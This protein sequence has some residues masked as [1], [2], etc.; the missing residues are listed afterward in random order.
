MEHLNVAE[1]VDDMGKKQPEALAIA[2]LKGAKVHK[3][4]CKDLMDRSN[5]LAWA[6]NEYGIGYGMHTAMMVTPGEELFALTFALFKVGAVPVFIDPGMGLDNVTKCLAEAK[7]EAFIGLTKA[8]I[9]R[10]LKGWGK[11][12][13]KKFVTV[14]PRLFF[15]GL[16]YNELLKRGSGKKLQIVEVTADTPA[17]INFTSGSTGRAKGA[18]Y[19]HGMFSTQVR[20]IRDVY[21]IKAGEVDCST[22]PLFALFD[23]AMGMTSVIPDMDTSKPGSSNPANIVRAVHLF[24]CTNMFA[25]PVVVAKVGAYCAK[26]G[27]K[28]P[29]LK[30]VISCGA[31]VAVPQLSTFVKALNNETQVH[32]PYG[33][34]EALPISDIGSKEIFAETAEITNNGG[35]VC[36][37]RANPEA[38]IKVITITDEAL[39][40]FDPTLELGPN[41]MGEIIVRG[42]MVSKSYFGRDDYTKLAKINDKDGTFWHRMGDVGYFDEKGRLFMCGRKSHRVV[43]KERT[44]Y[45][46]PSE[47]VFNKCAKIK[48]SALVGIKQNGETKA[49]ICIELPKNSQV[50]KKALKEELLAL[51]QESSHAK[52]I[53]I[54]L[55]YPHSFPMDV[56]HNAKIFREKL[57]IW[58]SEQ[59]K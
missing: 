18:I 25:N 13:L 57:A 1:Y 32:T 12:T 59:I 51:A 30:R 48:R 9:A 17:A 50:D 40:N 44:Y 36:V 6:L 55:F 29:S 45:T 19:T 35:G 42:P 22:F 23:A 16:S 21:G 52:G 47:A 3:I 31:P 38:Q 2:V 27:E 46:L 7:P 11:S 10:L 8:H 26:S 15:C 33:A 49:A 39:P 14:G 24:N 20:L 54:I 58:A 37:G 53:E 34:T 5:A 28:L 43:T 56:R 4:T 41:T